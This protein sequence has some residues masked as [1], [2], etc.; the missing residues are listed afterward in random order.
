[1]LRHLLA[2]TS[3]LLLS[4]PPCW[5]CPLVWPASCPVGEQEAPGSCCPHEAAPEPAPTRAPCPP[6]RC[7]C[8]RDS[9][10]LPAGKQLVPCPPGAA[11]AA[12]VP[13]PPASV[14]PGAARADSPHGRSPP[15][16]LVYCVWLC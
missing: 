6:S 8:E 3:G 10:F 9:T 7:C 11:F 15:L 13:P 1:R 14:R 16:R 12:P 4:L 2:L 5:A